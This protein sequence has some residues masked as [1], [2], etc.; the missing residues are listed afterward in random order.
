[1]ADVNLEVLVLEIASEIYAKF[2]RKGLIFWVEKH[3]GMNVSTVR[4]Q[5]E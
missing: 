3:G 5:G 1:M 2:Q 4:R